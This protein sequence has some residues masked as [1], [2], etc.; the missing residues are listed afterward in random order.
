MGPH[1]AGPPDGP[2]HAGPPDEPQQAGSPDEPQKVGPPDGIHALNMNMKGPIPSSS[3]NQSPL[4]ISPAPKI[5]WKSYTRPNVRRGATAKLT[6]SLYKAMLLEAKQQNS[7]KP[8]YPVNQ[9]KCMK[10]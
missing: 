7:C 9:N 5:S 6:S 8:K 3:G 4:H 2:H 1:H 10:D